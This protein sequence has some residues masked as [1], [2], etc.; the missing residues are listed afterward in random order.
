MPLEACQML[1]ADKSRPI[2]KIDG[3]FYKQTHLSHPCTRWCHEST[4]NY[5]FVVAYGLALCE[6]YEKRFGRKHAC[7]L[8]L[9]QANDY[10]QNKF[11]EP[12]RFAIAISPTLREKAGISLQTEMP[13]QEAIQAYRA[14]L[15]SFKLHYA[16][17]AHCAPPEW[18][19]RQD[20]NGRL[21]CRI[22]IRNTL[23]QIEAENQSPDSEL[24]QILDACGKM[25][26]KQKQ[27]ICEQFHR[28][29]SPFC[30]LPTKTNARKPAHLND[31]VKQVSTKADAEAIANEI[32][33]I[34]QGRKN[35]R[36]ATIQKR[37]QEG[38]TPEQI[39]STY[40]SFWLKYYERTQR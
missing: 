31:S 26:P 6:E 40:T 18:W 28:G 10:V 37:L 32:K 30:I 25:P 9:L 35:P 4:I 13:L 3:S 8:P 33:S 14:Y 22:K 15:R 34:L 5:A 39:V 12:A 21:S 24:Q 29:E 1:A 20:F 17:W 23:S 16:E 19:P 7:R 36:I 11:G 2:Q 27:E 38:E